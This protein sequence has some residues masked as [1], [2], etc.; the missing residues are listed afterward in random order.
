MLPVWLSW[1]EAH[2]KIGSLVTRITII[3][4]TAMSTEQQLLQAKDI[5]QKVFALQFP[6]GQYIVVGGAV[7]AMH[8]I[9]NT[10]DIDIVG[11]P[12]LLE[13]LRQDDEWHTANRPSGEP[14]VCKGCI[15]VYP[16]VNCPAHH[17]E[18]RDLLERG[19]AIQGIPC[20]SINDVLLFKKGYGREKDL[21]DIERTEQWLEMRMAP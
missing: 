7:L 19:E 11:S 1:K 8:G 16:D 20:A 9:K 14:G 6:I 3:F 10:H 18:F 12:E 17:L 21:G 13:K 5:F 4:R 15:E 2:Q